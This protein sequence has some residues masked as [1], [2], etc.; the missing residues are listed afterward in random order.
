MDKHSEPTEEYFNRM[1][2]LTALATRGTVRG[3]FLNC[4][5]KYFIERIDEEDDRIRKDKSVME[6]DG[7]IE[8]LLG[9]LMAQTDQR[10]GEIVCE[11]EH[12]QSQRENIMGDALFFA[13]MREGMAL[14][15]MFNEF[16]DEFT[17]E[18]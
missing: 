12:R 2:T 16:A 10:T 11:L 14:R 18:D 1:R 7:H 13:G 3:A 8:K 15:Q 6:A 4:L 17:V 5:T 9:E